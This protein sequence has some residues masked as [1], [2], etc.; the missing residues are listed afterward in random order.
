[1]IKKRSEIL[2]RML[3][4]GRAVFLAVRRSRCVLGDED[5]SSHDHDVHLSHD[6]LTM[7]VVDFVILNPGCKSSHA[8]AM[9]LCWVLLCTFA[10]APGCSLRARYCLKPLSR[11]TRMQHKVVFD[12]CAHTA[13]LRLI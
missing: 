9:Q 11:N 1:M 6:V 5:C 13:V 8:R 10:C 2:E 4:C 7:R 3:C 12:R